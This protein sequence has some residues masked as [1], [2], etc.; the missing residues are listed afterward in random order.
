MP[1]I[2]IEKHQSYNTSSCNFTTYGNYQFLMVAEYWEAIR[3]ESNSPLADFG[4]RRHNGFVEDC[5]K[6]I[7]QA[8]KAEYELDNKIA[9]EILLTVP[10]LVMRFTLHPKKGIPPLSREEKDRLQRQMST[11]SKRTIKEAIMPDLRESIWKT[12]EIKIERDDDLMIYEQVIVAKIGSLSIAS[13][14]T[15]LSFAF[16]IEVGGD[17]VVGRQYS[18]TV[19]GD[20]VIIWV[21]YDR[22]GENYGSEV[23]GKILKIY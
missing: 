8:V 3:P 16:P 2:N 21:D 10:V 22:D 12:I 11:D 15:T 7:K 4:K 23:K 19:Y 18:A 13:P 14:S 6:A 17:Y 5:I 20:T 9:Q 1:Q